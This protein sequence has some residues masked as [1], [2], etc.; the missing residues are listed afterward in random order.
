[1]SQVNRRQFLNIAAGVST[2]G[3]VVG[4]SGGVAFAAKPEIFTGLVDGVAVGGFDP[5]AYFT[6]NKAVEGSKEY[7]LSHNGAE[8]RFSS[9]ENKAL[10]MANPDR[11]APQ[12]GGY[13]AYAV[14]YG[15]TAKGE[16]EVWR[17]VDDKLYLNFS[18][19]VQKRWA[20]DI[21]GNIKKGNENW[22]NVL[23][24]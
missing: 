7:T 15:G 16:P 1:M 22:P 12:F 2:L 5:V 20:K 21:P 8:W 24:N 4:F 6:V 17:I 19:G 18:K 9:A 3:A 13:C 23:T 14:S 10:F 11:Y